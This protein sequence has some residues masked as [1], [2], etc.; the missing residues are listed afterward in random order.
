MDVHRGTQD[1]GGNAVTEQGRT[2]EERMS[3]TFVALA[4]TLV[5]GFDVVELLDGLLETAVDLLEVA[6]G[7]LLLADQRG[8]LRVMASSNEQTRLLELLQIQSDEGPCLV[9]YRTGAALAITDLAAEQSRWPQFAAEAERL[10]FSAVYTVPMRLRTETIG[11]INLFDVAGHTVDDA[12]LVMAQAL[13]D[14]AT[15]GILQHRT[16]QRTEELAEQ[17]QS[18]LHSR[19]LIEQAKGV[20]AEREGVDMA[21]A[22]AALRDYARQTRQRLA[23]VASALIAGSLDSSQLRRHPEADSS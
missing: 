4:D 15:I 9:S 18:A 1:W 10:S 6:A 2:R 11:A 16:I 23:D 13:A 12:D 19:V 17:L 3:R 21:E 20:L 14:V 7:G 8:Q 5:T 22:F